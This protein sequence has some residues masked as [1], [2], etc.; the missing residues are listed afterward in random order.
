MT[1][2]KPWAMV[3]TRQHS[4]NKRNGTKT[5]C[6]QIKTS[7]RKQQLRKTKSSLGNKYYIKDR[8]VKL[9]MRNDKRKW[10]EDM[11]TGAERA[12][13]NGHI[14]TVYKITRVMACTK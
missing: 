1:F 6:K 3:T 11:I 7:A 14:K 13:Y 8:E 4:C 2:W 12:V 10:T 9:S 5:L